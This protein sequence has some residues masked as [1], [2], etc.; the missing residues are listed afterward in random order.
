MTN[1]NG[2]QDDLA[3]L[4]GIDRAALEKA[5]EVQKEP[6]R[7]GE[8]AV[9]FA[10]VFFGVA[11]PSLL[12]M[13][14]ALSILYGMAKLIGP[15]LARSGML[16]ET[17]P[18]I[19]A[20]N[21]YE[22]ALLG[23]LLAIVLLRKASGDAISLTALVALFLGAT[24]IAL[25]T[26]A[27]DSPIAAGAV[28]LGCF[29]LALVKLGLLR[30]HVLP[31]LTGGLLYGAC[32]LLAWNFLTAP[33]MAGLL[34][35]GHANFPALRTAWLWA[36][37]VMLAATVLMFVR[38]LQTPTGS[39]WESDK[40]APLLHTQAMTWVFAGLLIVGG[41]VHQYALAYVFNA[42]SSFRDYVPLIAVLSLMGLELLRIYGVRKPGLDTVV[43][44]VPLA[45]IMAAMLAKGSPATVR[46]EMIGLLWRP[47]L[48]S[49]VM[50]AAVAGLSLKGGR[51]WLLWVALAYAL[52]CVLVSKGVLGRPQTLNWNL[53]GVVV[54]VVLVA[55]GL[56]RREP[57]F[58]VGAVAVASVG[59][60]Q[61]SAV[62]RMAEA[63]A[64]SHVEFVGGLA[65]MGFLGIYLAYPRRIPP[66]L[67]ALAAIV[68]VMCTVTAFDAPHGAVEALAAGTTTAGLGVLTWYRSRN[69][70]GA[71][72]LF[73]PL[74]R[75]VYAASGTTTGWQ[76][77]M[78]SFVLL[79]VGAYLS[80]RN[81]RRAKGQPPTT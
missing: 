24:G 33:A 30:K 53:F 61:S 10:R 36:W 4:F 50:A 17:L 60:L 25:D 62:A 57:W 74:A 40:D 35:Y 7:P 65:G 12:Y 20:L 8:N 2:Q 9:K 64:F 28:A 38:A 45:L 70:V 27:N 22:L 46:R 78:V 63:W 31:F 77:V 39:A 13:L 34:W 42:P 79:A 71:A 21:A 18:C 55:L 49:A 69:G 44:S 76:Y 59:M 52:S 81:G 80:L 72:V 15:V 41:G 56:V 51:R 14:S 3:R 47:W 16:R 32:M 5:K 1:D 19:A 58:F 6:E 37:L 26:V 29:V 68:L 75:T 43:A 23:V 54:L 48:L 67:G 73:A 66:A 11:G